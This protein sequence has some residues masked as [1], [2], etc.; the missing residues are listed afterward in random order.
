MMCGMKVD[1]ARLKAR[2]AEAG[3]NATIKAV[4]STKGTVQQWIDRLKIPG[5][6]LVSAI[7]ILSDA[8]AE[9][10]TTKVIK[11]GKLTKPVFHHGD[12]IV[13]GNLHVIGPLFVTGNLSVNGVM[14]DA[15]PDSRVAI[16]G[17]LVVHCGALWCI[18]CT[19]TATSRY[20]ARST[21]GASYTATTTITRW[22]AARFARSS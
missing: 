14:R 9:P 20:A 7:A 19:P 3:P 1:A 8:A 17:G 18:A 11:G 16:G 22:C 12:L 6:D 5:E 4:L 10:G 13:D 21:P 15:G 2:L